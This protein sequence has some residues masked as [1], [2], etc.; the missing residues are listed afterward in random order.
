M[1]Y[2]Q[3]R[4]LVIILIIFGCINILIL[5]WTIGTLGYY[6]VTVVQDP[7]YYRSEFVPQY[8][9]M[10]VLYYAS[11]LTIIV[12]IVYPVMQLRKANLGKKKISIQ[13]SGI[14]TKTSIL[15]S[16]CGAEILDTSG[17]FC[18]KCGAPLK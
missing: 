17:D 16:S 13:P 6:D 4:I 9:A 18:S 8:E 3:L 12:F 15:C 10:I 7:W 2:K 5:Q 14:R 1:E 11:V